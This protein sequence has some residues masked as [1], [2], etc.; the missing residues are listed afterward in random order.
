MELRTANSK[1]WSRVTKFYTFSFIVY[2]PTSVERPSACLFA[3]HGCGGCSRGA[4]SRVSP[5]LARLEDVRIVQHESGR[6]EDARA[7]LVPCRY[8]GAQGQEGLVQ[9]IVTARQ[10]GCSRSR[11]G[12]LQRVCMEASLHQLPKESALIVI[13]SGRLRGW[14]RGGTGDACGCVHHARRREG[15][16]GNARGGRRTGNCDLRVLLLADL[17]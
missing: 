7:Y 5:G 16:G 10:A 8:I 9:G 4:G 15:H 17:R 13:R 12:A 2:Y 3:A 6:V 11:A 14:G 1:K